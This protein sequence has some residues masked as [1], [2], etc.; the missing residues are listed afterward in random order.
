M[1]ILVLTSIFILFSS[2]SDKKVKPYGY[3]G[4]SYQI[5]MNYEK[6]VVDYTDTG[7]DVVKAALEESYS[8]SEITSN[9]GLYRYQASWKFGLGVMIDLK[10]NYVLYIEP[11]FKFGANNGVNQFYEEKFKSYGLSLIAAYKFGKNKE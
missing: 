6:T 1:P 3:V 10:E 2:S 4:F 7:L 5:M 11:N 8:G 9:T